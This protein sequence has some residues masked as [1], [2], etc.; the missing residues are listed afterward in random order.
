MQENQNIEQKENWRDEYLNGFVV[1]PMQ[2]GVK[3]CILKIKFYRVI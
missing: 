2:V 3:Y 1:L